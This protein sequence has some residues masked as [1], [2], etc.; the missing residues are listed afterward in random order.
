MLPLFEKRTEAF[1]SIFILLTNKKRPAIQKNRSFYC[2]IRI[3][4]KSAKPSL[5]SFVD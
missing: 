5:L 4:L 2:E 3:R 1:L